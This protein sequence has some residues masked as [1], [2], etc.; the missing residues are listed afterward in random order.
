DRIVRE[1]DEP[2]TVPPLAI[3]TE[4]P[5]HVLE[6][7]P[8][9]VLMLVRIAQVWRL[10]R[11]RDFVRSP[12]QITGTSPRVPADPRAEHG[13]GGVRGW[14]SAT[15]HAEDVAA[16]VWRGCGGGAPRVRRQ[17]HVHRRVRRALARQPGSANP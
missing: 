7:R 8:M 3:G 1:L 17:L 13:P 6:D 10:L 16:F 2:S 12:R 4:T 15:L 14:G 5:S 11:S 9:Q